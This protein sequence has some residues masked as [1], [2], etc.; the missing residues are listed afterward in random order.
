MEK[1]V[2]LFDIHWGYERRGGHKVPIHDAK[3]IS[4]VM[5]FVK[6][7]KPDHF[8]LGGDALDCSAVSHHRKGKVGQVEGLRL[9][10]DAKELRKEIISP[11]EKLVKGRK[12]YHI[13]NHEDWLN[14]VIDETPALEGIVGAEDLLDLDGWEVVTVGGASKLG[15]LV[16]IHGD[17]LKGGENPAKY[18]VTAYERSVRFGHFHTYQVHTKTAA[19]DMAPH[20]GIAV[21][22]LCRKDLKYAGGSPNKVAQGF[23]Y[24]Y[25][26]AK[27]GTFNDYVV[28]ITDGRFTANGKIYGG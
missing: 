26:D 12:I 20:T 6:D 19:V 25:V 2:A 24:G 4:A 11:I 5:E 28:V 13:G 15:K 22:C 1:F 7:F 18:A 16:F 21:P 23:L 27:K 8:I 17:Q 9:A 10:Q 3:A 14:D